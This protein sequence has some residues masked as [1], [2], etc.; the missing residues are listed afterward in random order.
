[1][2]WAK[3]AA[4]LLLILALGACGLRPLYGTNSVGAA[5]ADKLGTVNIGVIGERSGQTLRAEL[6]RTLNPDGR[7]S[8]PAYDLAVSLAESEQDVNIISDQTTTRKNLTLTASMVLTDHKTGQPVFSDTATEIT[9]F[10]ILSDQFT[11]LVGERDARDRAL[12]SLSE[13]IRTRLAL[14][15]DRH[16]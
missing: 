3:R 1:M 12:K 9:S 16:P 4:P 11:T 5:M 7:P 13:D 15:F 6:I 14:Y 10:N 2:S 8:Q